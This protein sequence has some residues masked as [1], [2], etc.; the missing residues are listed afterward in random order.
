MKLLEHLQG[1]GVVTTQD[2][3]EILANYDIRITQEEMEAGSAAASHPGAKHISGQV[4]SPQDPSFAITHY[5]EHMTLKME[6]GRRFVFF[7]RD[8][9]GKIGLDKWIG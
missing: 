7:H 8:G 4:W 9:S 2:G 6:D 5:R 1:L 3:K